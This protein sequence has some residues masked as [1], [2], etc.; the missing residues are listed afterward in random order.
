[1]WTVPLFFFFFF[2]Q[3]RTLCSAE[4]KINKRCR[5]YMEG[6]GKVERASSAVLFRD[7]CGHEVNV[8]EMRK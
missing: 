2:T 1:M 6:R 5:W 4:G 3:E 7:R 8:E